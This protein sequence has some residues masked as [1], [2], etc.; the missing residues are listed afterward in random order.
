MRLEK[1]SIVGRTVQMVMD[2]AVLH[3]I[4]GPDSGIKSFIG[5]VNGESD[6]KDFVDEEGWKK[7]FSRWLIG[8]DWS[9]LYD[10]P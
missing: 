4:E 1:K 8:L 6:V 7:K 10:V 3:L 2:G 9:C 5:K